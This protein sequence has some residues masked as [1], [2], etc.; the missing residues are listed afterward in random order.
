MI[1]YLADKTGQYKLIM[2][3]TLVVGVGFHTFIL[4]LEEVSLVEAQT[5][6]SASN[7]SSQSLAWNGT[8]LGFELEDQALDF[9][10]TNLTAWLTVDHCYLPDE[11]I[12]ATDSLEQMVIRISEPNTNQ[13]EA[14]E[15]QVTDLLVESCPS[16]VCSVDIE[17]VTWTATTVERVG[18]PFVFPVVLIIRLVGFFAVDAV[19]PLLDSTSQYMTKVQGGDFGQQKMW[20][21]ISYMVIPVFCGFLVDVIAVKTGNPE[22]TVGFTSKKSCTLL[23]K[24]LLMSFSLV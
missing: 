12:N 15:D 4:W 11:C 3:V 10:L 21:Y 23:S 17:N 20:A 9:S 24:I 1:G 7:F 16:F 6:E 8:V 22:W 19:T 13:W 14:A 18:Q 2:S 5:V